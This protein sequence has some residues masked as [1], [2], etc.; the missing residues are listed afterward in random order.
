MRLN[1]RQAIVKDGKVIGWTTA[2]GWRIASKAL[3]TSASV[4]FVMV[5]GVK[6]LAWIIAPPRKPLLWKGDRP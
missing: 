3:G 5:E 2:T 6:Q 4:G 1:N